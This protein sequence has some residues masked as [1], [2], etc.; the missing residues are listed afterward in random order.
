MRQ[1]LISILLFLSSLQVFS[2]PE[3]MYGMYDKDGKHREMTEKMEQIVVQHEQAEKERQEK[4]TFIL[5]ISVLMGLVP[6]AYIGY[7]V[8]KERQWQTN[9]KGTAQAL[10]I[11]LLGGMALFAFNF[12][13]LYLKIIHT[14]AFYRF[15]PVVGLI[16]IVGTIIMINRKT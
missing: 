6:F 12:G 9:R 10:G 14:S 1:T 8:T 15:G 7:K 3:E 13:L 2:S 4:M 16:I 5:C 11:A